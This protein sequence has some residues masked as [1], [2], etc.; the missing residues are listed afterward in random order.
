M[1]TKL[2][3]TSN[4]EGEVLNSDKMVLVDF[5]ATWCGPCKILAPVL[6]EI[7][8]ETDQAKV[9]KVNIDDDPG[10]AEIYNISCVPTLLYFKDGK[11]VDSLI[12]VNPK[13]VIQSKIA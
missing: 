9:C 13:N 3:N 1:A 7:S 5:Y 11:P 8:E 12:G 2:V 6:E 4:F 10:L